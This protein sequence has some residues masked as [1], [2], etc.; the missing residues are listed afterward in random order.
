MY[1]GRV[2]GGQKLGTQVEEFVLDP[3]EGFVEHGLNAL[4]VRSLAAVLVV[5]KPMKFC[6]H[7]AQPT[8]DFVATPTT[9][10]R[11]SDFF[12]RDPST[13]DDSPPSPPPV[14]RD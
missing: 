4:D 10:K 7:H 5:G 14:Y 13:S 12:R 2:A 1:S 11:T 8:V 6:K 3:D 9:S